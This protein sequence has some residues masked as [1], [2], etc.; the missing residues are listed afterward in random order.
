V[1]TKSRSKKTAPQV[2]PPPEVKPNGT[3]GT[4]VPEEESILQG[5][6][7]KEGVKHFSPLDLARFELAQA[8]V[9]DA[10]KDIRL[11]QMDMNQLRLN[12]EQAAKAMQDRHAA[13]LVAL[14]THEKALMDLRQEVAKVYQVDI[15]KITYNDTSGEIMYPP[16]PPPPDTN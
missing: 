8:K 11:A 16:E 12:F 3:S 10:Q 6:I 14:R 5:P 13:A 4:P 1:T 15:N 9:I 2:A 7:F